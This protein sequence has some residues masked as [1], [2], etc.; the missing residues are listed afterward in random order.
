MKAQVGIEIADHEAKQAQKRAEG[1]AA[2]IRTTATA[3]AER[4]QR[5][6]T[7]RPASSAPRARRRPRPTATR[8]PALTAQG[9]T[10]VEV[11]KAI[12]GAG[13]KIT[14][15]I[16]VSAAAAT[17][18]QPG[19][20]GAAAAREHAPAARRAPAGERH[21]REGSGELK[22]GQRSSFSRS[23]GAGSR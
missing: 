5:W 2:R 22:R 10:A 4:I 13:L 1:E 17:T 14:P 18:E 3:E 6:A 11:M 23:A 21:R 19:R 8:S 16:M 20:A 12:T 7:A 15:D 9:V